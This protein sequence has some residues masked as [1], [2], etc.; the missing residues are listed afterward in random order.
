MTAAR[1]L[2]VVHPALLGLAWTLST[3]LATGTPTWALWRPAAITVIIALGVQVAVSATL[4]RGVTAALVASIV[5]LGLTATWLFALPLAGVVA[6]WLIVNRVRASRQRPAIPIRFLDQLSSG[7]GF[8]AIVLTLLLA[9]QT[10]LTPDVPTGPPGSSG[11]PASPHPPDIYMVLLDGYPRA[12]VLE[13]RFGI[14]IGPFVDALEERGFEVHAQSRS[15]Y[16]ST[17][18]TLASMFQMAYLEDIPSVPDTPTTGPEQYRVLGGLVNSSPAVATLRKHGYRIVVSPSPYSELAVHDA[19]EFADTI[20]PTWFE[21]QLLEKSI[22]ATALD[23]LFPDLFASGQRDRIEGGLRRLATA[24]RGMAPTFFFDH[25]LSPH[26]P[27]VFSASG[28][29]VPLEACFPRTCSLWA[30]TLDRLSITK[31]RYASGLQGQIQYLN[32]RLLASVDELLRARPDAVVVFFSDHGTRY[33]V[34]AD[35][36]EATMNFIATRTPAAPGL[37]GQDVSTVNLLSDLLN[38]YLGTEL[39]HQPF[40]AWLS[41]G[42]SPLPLVRLP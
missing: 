3:Y 33:D 24:G 32:R 18:A 16:S 1:L 22:A 8:V 31:A 12:D 11:E 14:D 19:D 39:P 6:W 9:W 38:Q 10:A 30:P 7:V 27:F 35:P 5:V 21:E 37:Y 4:R 29:S 23:F 40:K 25:I 2:A 13:S 36:A 17:W 42:D 26:P 20:G 15:N 34:R 28:A 41:T